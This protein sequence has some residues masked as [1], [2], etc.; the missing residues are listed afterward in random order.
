MRYLRNYKDYRNINE[1]INK[2]NRTELSSYKYIIGDGSLNESVFTDTLDRL[3]VIAK[4]GLLTT[5][6]FTTLM[7]TPS[8]ADNF[9]NLPEN[10]KT[11]ITQMIKDGNK[12]PEKTGTYQ[13]SEKSEVVVVDLGKYFKSGRYK[14]SDTDKAQMIKELS[15]IKNFLD[16]NGSTVV[17]T[18]VASESRVPNRDAETGDKLGPGQL[19]SKRYETAVSILKDILGDSVKIEKDLKIGGPEYKGDDVNQEKYT[20]HQY[21]KIKATNKLDIWNFNLNEEGEEATKESGYIGGDYHFDASEGEGI[22]RLRPGSIPDRCRVF[23]DGKEIADSGFFTSQQHQY[24]EFKYVPLYVLSLT[25][26]YNEDPNSDAIRGVKI[27]DIKN[28]DELKSLLLNDKSY[29]MGVS[30]RSETDIPL[31]ELIKM[32]TDAEKSGKPMKVAIY[33]LEIKDLDIKLSNND[34]KINIKVY[35][36]VKNTKFSITGKG[37]KT[38]K[39]DL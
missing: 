7:S 2:L 25:K 26:M 35:S 28:V 5:A 13:Y 3:K 37:Q 11:E 39:V 14:I 20:K 15:K 33:S 29:K 36:P 23:V 34:K 24:K 16:K 12:T 21:V 18:I 8:F 9:N 4:K 38:K 30:N 32:A 19:S 22:I 31:A 10:D 17:V 27:V 6:L 1:N